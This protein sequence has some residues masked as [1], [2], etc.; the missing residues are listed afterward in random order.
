MF[1]GIKHSFSSDGMTSASY[2]DGEVA[3]YV[4]FMT[5]PDRTGVMSAVG[6]EEAVR[7]C[8]LSHWLGFRNRY[9]ATTREEICDYA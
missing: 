5:E 1:E 3:G 6:P 2:T 7:E 9:R 8:S 4:S